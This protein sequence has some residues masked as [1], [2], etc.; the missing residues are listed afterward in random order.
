MLKHKKNILLF[1]ITLFIFTGCASLTPTAIRYKAV[2]IWEELFSEATVTMPVLVTSTYTLT[3][4]KIPTATMTPTITLTPTKTTV[5]W[6]NFVLPT[7]EV[8]ETQSLPLS[9]RDSI[10][11]V[12]DITIPDDTILQPNQLFIKSWR[13][14]NSGS[15]TWDE[16]Q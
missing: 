15:N 14:T 13:M 3:P 12:R 10:N 9:V 16:S 6:S 5:P 1:V 2:H 8:L 7:F 11:Q 4:T